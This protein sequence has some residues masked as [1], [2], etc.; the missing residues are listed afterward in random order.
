MIEIFFKIIILG[1]LILFAAATPVYFL[2]FLKRRDK[3]GEDILVGMSIAIISF[4]VWNTIYFNR[5]NMMVSHWSENIIY[6]G[7]P[8]YIL[9]GLIIMII[10]IV[11]LSSK[12]ISSKKR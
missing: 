12:L 2:N 6:L 3:K 9:V 5:V 1:I 7:G 4:L 10:T 8:V 11:S